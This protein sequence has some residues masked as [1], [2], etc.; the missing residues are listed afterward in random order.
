[1]RGKVPVEKER[2]VKGE[3]SYTPVLWKTAEPTYR[4][5]DNANS[6]YCNNQ[7]VA[8]IK[9]EMSVDGSSMKLQCLPAPIAKGVWKRGTSVISKLCCGFF[10]TESR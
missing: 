8:I 2:A 10:W 3:E 7:N 6:A 5:V 9:G 1:M 4:R